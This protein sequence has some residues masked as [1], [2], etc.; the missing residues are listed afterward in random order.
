MATGIF[1]RYGFSDAYNVDREY[2]DKDVVGIALGAGLLMLEN[3]RRE[4]IWKTF[5]AIPSS[6]AK[7]LRRAGLQRAAPPVPAAS[8]AW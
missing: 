3:H 5:M 8:T 7:A 4:T 2:W 6:C 1:G